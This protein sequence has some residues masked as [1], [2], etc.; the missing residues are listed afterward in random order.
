MKQSKIGILLLLLL[1]ALAA[2]NIFGGAEPEQP[3]ATEAGSSSGELALPTPSPT[4]TPVP[5]ATATSEQ[6]SSDD[7]QASDSTE[8]GQS[9]VVGPE[10]GEITFALGA[11]ADYEPIEPNLFFTTGIT[12]VHAIF[13][14]SGMSPDYTWER[15]WTLND[16][17]V[18][19]IAETWA[20]PEAGVFDYFINN[21]GRPLPA[22]DWV[23]EIYVEGE[24][25]SLGVFI[26]EEAE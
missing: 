25:R 12:E 7:S 4:D 10:I 13:D 18:T 26:I 5:Q 19:R 24:L 3:V 2:C 16:N 22:G 15:V 1:T 6:S 20:G 17:E 14:Y 21:S 8:T 23:L 9:E 11:T